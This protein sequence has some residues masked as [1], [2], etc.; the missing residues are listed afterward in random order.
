MLMEKP[1]WAKFYIKDSHGVEEEII[2]SD[3]LTRSQIKMMSSQPDMLV[4]FSRTL[5]NKYLEIQG[6]DIKVRA[7]VWASLNGRRSQL[8]IEP[9]TDLSALKNTWGERDYV[10]PLDS[11]ISP[12]EYKNLEPIFRKESKW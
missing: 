9:F 7:E 8:F 11:V 6:R 12:L 3:W 10:L 2:L 4:Q 1:S 5:K